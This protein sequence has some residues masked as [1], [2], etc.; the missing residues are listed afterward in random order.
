MKSI[1]IIGIVIVLF[2]VVNTIEPVFGVISYP[3]LNQRLNDLPT[4]CIVEPYGY[5]TSDRGKYVNM[6][7]NGVTAWDTKLQG[8]E[9]INPSI[10]EMKSKIISSSTDTSGCDIVMSFK[11]NV[12]QISG[13]GK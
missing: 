4:Y 10:W 5:A 2:F 8:Y 3:S 12:E 11:N 9:T 7:V 1:A 6:A 13:D